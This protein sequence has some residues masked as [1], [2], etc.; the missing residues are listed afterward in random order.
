VDLHL[1]ERRALVTGSAAGI[2][3]AIAR[4]LASEGVA[5]VVHGRDEQRG[6]RLA[7]ELTG[8]GRRAIFIGADL[9]ARST[10]LDSHLKRARRLAPS[11]GW[12]VGVTPGRP[13]AHNL[14]FTRPAR[15]GDAV[16]VT[17]H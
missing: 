6:Q 4:Q 1:S 15:T 3:A 10:S 16:D 14:S 12:T 17:N 2:E 9:R 11:Y 5:V 7:A 13:E 8:A